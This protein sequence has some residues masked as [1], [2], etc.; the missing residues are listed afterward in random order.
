MVN[1][2][3]PNFRKKGQTVFFFSRNT[4]RKHLAKFGF[5][6]FFYSKLST[7][8]LQAGLVYQGKLLG[9]ISVQNRND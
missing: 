8:E 3:S 1:K 5:W 7:S 6:N 9:L 2:R 4:H